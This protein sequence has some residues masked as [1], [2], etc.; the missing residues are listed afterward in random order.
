MKKLKTIG[1]ENIFSFKDLSLDLDNYNF[2]CVTGENGAG[3]SSLL[4]IPRLVFFKASQKDNLINDN[5]KKGIC[6]VT[7]EID[8]KDYN[9]SRNIPGDKLFINGNAIDQQEFEDILGL[10]D[11]IF[12]N[13]V[14]YGQ[15]RLNE[16]ICSTPAKQMELFTLMLP[17]LSKFDSVRKIV[18]TEQ[19][20]HETEINLKQNKIDS[21]ELFLKETNSKNLSEE[22]RASI[23]LNKEINEKLIS[24]REKYRSVETALQTEKRI[25]D[26]IKKMEAAKA[27]YEG[28]KSELS[29][30]IENKIKLEQEIKT[31][32]D[33][34][35]VDKLNKL[36]GNLKNL[37]AKKGEILGNRK[38]YEPILKV[39][40]GVCPVCLQKIGKDFAE[41][42]KT[43]IDK[44]IDLEGKTLISIKSVEA[45]IN[46]QKDIGN[47]YSICKN[48]VESEEFKINSL[49]DSVKSVKL[50][51]FEMMSEYKKL[52]ETFIK[53]EKTESLILE[54]KELEKQVSDNTERAGRLKQLLSQVESETIKLKK[55][56]E[57]LKLLENKFNITKYWY[58]QLPI[59]KL[60][61]V[62]ES[63][64]LLEAVMNGNMVELYPRFKI[65][66][67]SKAELKS[68]EVRDKLNI[69]IITEQGKIRGWGD[70]SG[71]EK[72]RIALGCQLAIPE[73]LGHDFGFEI[74]D[75]I[76]KSM[77]DAGQE[78]AIN[79]LQR[80]SEDKQVFVISHDK[81]LYSRF[82]QNIHVYM[83][84]KGYSKIQH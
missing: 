53:P 68:G 65:V 18:S 70:A 37:I 19:T 61:M 8:G 3:K 1:C 78:A 57:E 51:H 59:I 80:R 6:F 33:K 38:T 20:Q 23:I 35:D 56:K 30:R 41:K 7:L 17:Y 82:D 62:E 52:K 45:E 72:S 9:I 77:D 4:S 60:K 48:N 32:E 21:I 63:L 84:D 11:R 34:I 31:L 50:F 29:M 16:F 5:A 40:S 74:Y 64:G 55:L 44:C 79:L 73:M 69:Q 83:D 15:D 71:G 58:S 47:K 42:A 39:N 2:C 12:C 24:C 67:T 75:E 76:F 66:I 25:S 54:I 46:C 49:Q 28:K 13:S 10:D 22:L 43:E 36:E 26:L 27:N 14:Y 81:N